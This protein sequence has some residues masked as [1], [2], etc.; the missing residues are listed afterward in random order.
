M[1]YH[2]AKDNGQAAGCYHSKQGFIN[3]QQILFL[4]H[5][6]PKTDYTG[7]EKQTFSLKVV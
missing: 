4:P 3:I 1:L 7:Q 5:T 6:R 2:C